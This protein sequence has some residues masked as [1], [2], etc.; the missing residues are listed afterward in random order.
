[1]GPRK[2]TVGGKRSKLLASSAFAKSAE[3]AAEDH[4]KGVIIEIA[5][6]DAALASGGLGSVLPTQDGS[7]QTNVDALSTG[8]ITIATPPGSTTCIFQ[9]PGQTLY[10]FVIA[11]LTET[12]AGHPW[13]AGDLFC[14]YIYDNQAPGSDWWPIDM[15]PTENNPASAPGPFLEPKVRPEPP[16]HTQ[17][18]T[19]TTA[20]TQV[21]PTP[22]VYTGN[23]W[24]P[25]ADGVFCNMNVSGA[26]FML[27]GGTKMSRGS[28]PATPDTTSD[29]WEYSFGGSAW[30]YKVI[31]PT[32]G[33]DV[34]ALIEANKYRSVTRSCNLRLMT[35]N[36]LLQ[37]QIVYKSFGLRPEQ[38]GATDG[39]DEGHFAAVSDSI[40]AAVFESIVFN[41]TDLENLCNTVTS[42]LINPAI[43]DKA[44]LNFKTTLVGDVNVFPFVNDAGCAGLLIANTVS[45]A[46]Y[47]Q[48]TFNNGRASW[49]NGVG[50]NY[51][52]LYAD[53]ATGEMVY[54]AKSMARVTALVPAT[55]GLMKRPGVY[56]ARFTRQVQALAA[57]P[58][59]ATL[60]SFWKTLAEATTGV[61]DSAK[62]VGDRVLQAAK[63]AGKVGLNYLGQAVSDELM[64]VLATI[65]L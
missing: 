32:H 9:A 4:A 45:D 29:Q 5:V 55:S 35:T 7:Q 33:A 65:V 12:P 34:L 42:D 57:L 26:P 3:A 30:Q 23:V 16:Y 40:N 28:L 64:A 24:F 56:H 15:V 49:S 58:V 20:G 10:A 21:A 14:P 48:G 31:R 37:A 50:V 51:L 2:A 1:M 11:Q 52:Y 46:S 36:S 13:N 43:P 38:L 63:T 60:H 22:I 59:T 62:Q 53:N 39:I 17:L 18:I 19:T 54:Q 47:N 44:G 25:R 27:I 6:P 8:Q 61:L 41:D